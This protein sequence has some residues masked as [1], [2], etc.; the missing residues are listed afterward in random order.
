MNIAWILDVPFQSLV[1]AL[2][3]PGSFCYF[4]VLNKFDRVVVPQ[5]I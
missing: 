1:E 5:A 3:F 4:P 2:T